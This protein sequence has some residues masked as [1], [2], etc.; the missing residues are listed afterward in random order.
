MFL[1]F[2]ISQKIGFQ[3]YLKMHFYFLVWSYFQNNKNNKQFSSVFLP[4]RGMEAVVH[5]ER[6]RQLQAQ[7]LQM[8]I[9]IKTIVYYFTWIEAKGGPVVMDR[10]VLSCLT[11]EHIVLYMWQ[12]QRCYG[13]RGLTITSVAKKPSQ[14][15]H[16]GA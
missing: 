6:D 16:K 10:L 4:H 8:T 9:Y 14:R 11:P 2:P 12:Q 15:G 7:E 1:S 5:I 3:S 13:R